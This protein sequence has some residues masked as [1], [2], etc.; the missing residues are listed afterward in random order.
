MTNMMRYDGISKLVPSCL[1]KKLE[2]HPSLSRNGGLCVFY[3][4]T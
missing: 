4:S 1:R 2:G 3:V